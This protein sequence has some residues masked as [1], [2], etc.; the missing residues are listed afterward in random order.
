MKIV[1]ILSF[2]AGDGTSEVVGTVRFKK[3]VSLSDVPEKMVDQMK[4]GIRGKNGNIYLP[5]DG[6]KFMRALRY[7]YSGSR[8]RATEVRDG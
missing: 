1:E 8:I 2:S 3:Q 7:A 6:L 4:D 5:K